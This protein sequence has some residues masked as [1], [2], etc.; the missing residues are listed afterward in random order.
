MTQD[1]DY[2]NNILHLRDTSK[3]PT[4]ENG[5][6]MVRLPADILRL[7]YAKTDMVPLLGHDMFVRRRVAEKLIAI[8][9]RLEAQD[10]PYQ[11]H[12]V[13]A[14]RAPAVQARYFQRAL[15]QVQSA[16]QSLPLEEQIELAHSMAA[17]PKVAGHPTGGAVDITLWNRGPQLPVDMGSDI[18][19]YG[20]PAYTYYP[21]LTN[22]RQKHRQ[23][24][25]DLMVAEQFAPF[26]GE[27]WHFSYGDKEW[28]AYYRQPAARYGPLELERVKQFVRVSRS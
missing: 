1:R 24:L 12:I 28:A 9:R 13:Y 6:S 25:Q 7:Q 26:L 11:L 17:H 20:D 14:Y 19:E 5:E 27:W 4:Q 18:A 16:N 23:Y 10:S 15:N 21:H 3:V 8:Q 2:K 22:E